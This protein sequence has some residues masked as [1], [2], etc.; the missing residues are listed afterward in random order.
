VGQFRT[1]SNKKLKQAIQN[2]VCVMFD[3]KEN[4]DSEELV[5]QSEL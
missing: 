4:F 1:R 3:H 5:H 2:R